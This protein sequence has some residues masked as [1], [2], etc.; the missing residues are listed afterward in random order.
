MVRLPKVKE[1]VVVGLFDAIREKASELLSG[2]TDKAG[3]LAD[4]I[5]GAQAAE[6]LTQSATDTAQE[7]AADV[8]VSL[9]DLPGDAPD[10]PRP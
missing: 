4:N 3:E 1:V 9:P 7:A 8:T 6:D 2:V 10:L 5:P